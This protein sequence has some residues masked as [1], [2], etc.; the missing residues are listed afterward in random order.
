MIKLLKSDIYRIGDTV[1]KN[2]EGNCEFVFY[3]DCNVYEVGYILLRSILLLFG[4]HM[5]IVS[6]EEYVDEEV[7][8]T[9]ALI[10]NL[11]WETFVK[12]GEEED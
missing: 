3:D 8:V 12:I 11:P 2:D 7:G 9:I 4:E 10:T 5:R 6:V 1:N